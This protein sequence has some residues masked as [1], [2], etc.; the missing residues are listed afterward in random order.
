M[1]S[2]TAPGGLSLAR[3]TVA[4]PKRRMDVALPDN[5][6]VAEL[7]PHLLRH[8]GDDLGDD[9]ERHGGWVLRR[10]TGAVLEPTRNLSVQGVRDGE[11]LH[12]APRRDD[13][14]E[15]AYDDVVEVIA[16][17]A[18]RAGRSW[19][20]AAT[21]RGGL[22][23]TSVVL[24]LGLVVLLIS[25]P[26]WP[27]PAAVG[28]GLATVLAVVGILLSRAFGDAAAGA[29]VAASGLPY[30]FAGGALLAAPGDTGITRLGASS[31]LLG[32]AALLVFSVIGYTGVA[33]IQRLFMAGIASSVIGL[34]A[35]LLCLMGMK[36][37]G[38]AAVA[39]T[40]VIGLLPS[41]PL[42]ASWIG[43]LP[44]PELP[45][46]AE[47]ILEDRPVPKRSDVFAAVAR[48]TELLSGMLLSAAICGALATMF[49]VGVEGSVSADLLAFAAAAALLLRARLFALPQQ[50][51]PLLVSGVAGLAL[52]LLGYVLEAD[53]G[54]GRLILLLVVLL[55]AAAVLAAGLVYSRRSPS[56]YLGRAADIFDVLAIM[57][58]VPL[59]C[60]V[61]GLFGE[62]QGLFGSIGG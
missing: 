26:P 20:S 33:A 52:L 62:I 35:S 55:A 46:R 5:L 2:V 44:V 57:A 59:A 1:T 28:L 61:A 36:P 42:I 22:A 12:L 29:V 10:A 19:G 48:S 45:E 39:L 15:L 32:S 9:G 8:A 13:W 6:L 38:A 16:S 58:L 53:S 18:R 50:R 17:G 34:L 25:G 51:V 3:V 60:A 49:L 43:R 40:A 23:V 37:G 14:P 11:L 24:A 47:D 31:L 30:A 4:A 7:L 27:L 21:R 56:P 41:Y 54:G